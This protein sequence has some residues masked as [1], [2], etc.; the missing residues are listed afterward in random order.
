MLWIRENKAPTYG[1]NEVL[2]EAVSNVAC[3]RSQDRGRICPTVRLLNETK[4]P[5]GKEKQEPHKENN[6]NEIFSISSGPRG[7]SQKN[8][9]EG[10]RGALCK[11]AGHVKEQ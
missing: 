8:Y 9:K 7:S 3:E 11:N 5:I 6:Q 1:E 4:P 10:L 2:D